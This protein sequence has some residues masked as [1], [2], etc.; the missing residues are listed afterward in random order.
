MN[1]AVYSIIEIQYRYRDFQMIFIFILA[2]SGARYLAYLI[3]NSLELWH[4]RIYLT[5]VDKTIK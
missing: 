5:T 3:K 4:Q 2:A 1:F